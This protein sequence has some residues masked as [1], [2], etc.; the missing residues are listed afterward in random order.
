MTQP[1]HALKGAARR[2][3][4]RRA[5]ALSAGGAALPLMLNLA[6]IGEAAAQTADDYKALV[7]VFL[8]G[9]NDHYN[10]VLPYDTPS[11]NSYAQLRQTL[12]RQRD[13]QTTS[14]LTAA[15]ALD[16]GRQFALASELA[17]LRR[18]WDTNQLALLLNVGPLIQP[19]T[20]AQYA[21]QNVPLPPK[22]FSHNDQQSIWQSLAAE[23]ATS[24]WGGRIADLFASG[25][26]S[27]VFTSI[28]VT[29][30]AVYL[31]GREVSQ[32]QVSPTGSVALRAKTAPVFG[33]STV[34]A[35]L[36][37]LVRQAGN[38]LFELE[39][40]RIVSRAI[41]ADE[42]LSGVL[43]TIAQPTGF[44]AEPLSAQLAMV[45]RLLQAQR[46]L[47]ARRQVFFVSLGG[48][49]LHDFL[50]DQ[51]PP[52]L[53]QIDSA[54]SS[55]YNALQSLGLQN[56]VTTFTASDF[57]RT[58]TSNGDGSDHGWGSHH[59]VMGGAVRG[60]FYGRTTAS[61]AVDPPLYANNGPDDVGG[62]RLLPHVSVD[63]FGATLARWFG[64]SASNLDMVF[65]N[66]ANFSRKDLGFL[67]GSG[68]T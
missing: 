18:I 66:L 67:V 28:S 49:D 12:A 16:G 20:K 26:S 62:G 5:G 52:L 1:I 22:L 23:G 51:H 27:A 21:A 64:V 4:L 32:Y 31:S 44:A 60:G 53:S 34:A 43:A 37:Q 33:S 65:P 11:Y 7:C 59:F 57:G 55:F 8:Y 56:S 39:H 10:T 38:N 17:G 19:T 13:A 14:A 47:G 35:T 36:Q 2:E 3:F 25:N 54:M 50:L 58:L 61:G 41:D 63:Q 29:G 15:R 40:A 68:Q 24:G 9:A 48:F 6:A 45:V 46:T 42:Q 30:N